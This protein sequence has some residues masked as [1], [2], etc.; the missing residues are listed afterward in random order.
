MIVQKYFL[1]ITGSHSEVEIQHRKV[2]IT[3]AMKLDFHHS[4]GAWLQI[5]PDSACNNFESCS[6][7]MYKSRGSNQLIQYWVD[8]K[9]GKH[10]YTPR[11]KCKQLYGH[12]NLR[13]YHTW[14]IFL[15][16]THL[17]TLIGNNNQY[18]VF[19][20]SFPVPTVACNITERS[21]HTCVQILYIPI[22]RLF[23]FILQNTII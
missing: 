14:V 17:L 19:E 21:I 9:C 2:G 18:V 12:V 8:C 5:N 4:L 13:T 3:N 10:I 7:V 6:I 23:Y 11:N 20:I 22:L 15:V 16:D 1:S